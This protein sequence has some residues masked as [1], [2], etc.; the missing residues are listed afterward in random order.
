MIAIQEV[1]SKEEVEQLMTSFPHIEFIHFFD[2]ENS[3]HEIE[4]KFWFQYPFKSGYYKFEISV[5]LGN[6]FLRFGSTAVT[7]E[8]RFQLWD[9]TKNQWAFFA[10]DAETKAFFASK[11]RFFEVKS[12]FLA[13]RNQMTEHLMSMQTPY[14]FFD[15]YGFGEHLF[16]EEKT[17]K[18]IIH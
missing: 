18:S 11:S 7:Q 16:L 1:I 4:R 15:T 17:K 3:L 12:L 8:L 13:I 10:S 6:W 9:E 2:K 14:H 5:E